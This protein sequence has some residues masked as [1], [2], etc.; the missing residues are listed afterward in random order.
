MVFPSLQMKVGTI[1]KQLINLFCRKRV[2]NFTEVI[3][4]QN[5]KIFDR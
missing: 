2:I 1:G 3:V 4:K 5:F